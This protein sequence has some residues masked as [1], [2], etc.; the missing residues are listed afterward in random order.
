MSTFS[1]KAGIE[2]MQPF[3]YPEVPKLKGIGSTY[4]DAI[5]GATVVQFT[6]KNKDGL[7]NRHNYCNWPVGSRSSH[8]ILWQACRADGYGPV[9]IAGIDPSTWQRTSK[10]V[11]PATPL[12]NPLNWQMAGWS[13]WNENILIGI[14][15]KSIWAYDASQ[16]GYVDR[17]L[18]CMRF[19]PA[20]T[21]AGRFAFDEA[22]QTFA[23]SYCDQNGN[24]KRHIVWRRA[25]NQIAF[26]VDSHAYLPLDK[27]CTPDK[28]G[29][30]VTVYYLPPHSTWTKGD[31]QTQTFD[32]RTG[33]VT[34]KVLWNV[35]SPTDH[36]ISH[37]AV[38]YGVRCGRSTGN[39][40]IYLYPSNGVNPTVTLFDKLPSW[41]AT[42]ASMTAAFDTSF[43]EVSF[44]QETAKQVSSVPFS[45]EIAAFATDGSMQYRRLAFHYCLPAAC[46]NPEW[47]YWLAPR[48]A[49]SD[50]L[51]FFTSHM[52][53]VSP[54]WG[55]DVFAVVIK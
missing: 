1:I 17:I 2:T 55:C 27:T 12:G 30:Y 19:A 36:Y 33:Q 41:Q 38:G 9:C 40:K 23:I 29:Q 28:T 10:Q 46:P 25:E 22:E 31:I 20:N 8:W 50:R 26:Q 47:S 18:D 42:H 5:T 53:D 51:V 11:L 13:A 43:L 21:Y 4:T 54:N 6:D 16:Q 15:G 49:V 48:A 45:G 52:L 7:R 3:P 24:F 34:R 32:I 14:D 39:N 44:Y 37:G 35:W